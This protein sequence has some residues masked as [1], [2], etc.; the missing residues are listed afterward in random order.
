VG[1][2]CAELGNPDDIPTARTA[3]ANLLPTSQ[4]NLHAQSKHSQ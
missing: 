2:H 4:R 3:S 1:R